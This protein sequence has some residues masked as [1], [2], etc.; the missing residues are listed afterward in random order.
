MAIARDPGGNVSGLRLFEQGNSERWVRWF[1][2]TATRA[3]TTTEDLM[4]QASRLL[5]QWSELVAGLRADHTERA[6]L[7]NLGFDERVRGSH[8]IFRKAGV[9][10]LINLQRDGNDA[11]PY[12]VTQVRRVISKYRLGVED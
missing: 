3:A 10:E 11:K 5:A 8:H 4:E 9:A 6:L 1:A 12:Q 2:E 7:R